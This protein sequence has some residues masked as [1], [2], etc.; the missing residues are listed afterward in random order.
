MHIFKNDREI[1]IRIEKG[2]D[3]IPALTRAVESLNIRTAWIQGIGASSSATFSFFD[4]KTK[5]YTS[6]TFDEPLE[7][8]SLLGNLTYVDDKPFWHIHGTFSDKDFRVYAGHVQ[9]LTV[10]VTLEIF[11][12]KLSLNLTRSKDEETGLNLLS[13]E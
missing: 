9:N 6:K 8:V 1:I 2:E 13:Q 11:F 10:G 12:S 3:V 4:I 7:I 5:E